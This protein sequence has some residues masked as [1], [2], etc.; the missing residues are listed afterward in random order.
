M[1]Q[2]LALTTAQTAEIEKRTTAWQAFGKQVAL[3]EIAIQHSVTKRLATIVMPTDVKLLSEYDTAKS[4]L[5]KLY[6]DTE[7][8]IKKD[9]KITDD[10]K[11]RR[12]LPL[13]DIEAFM[14][15]FDESLLRLK[16]ADAAV[17]QTEAAKAAEL[18]SFRTAKTLE[19]IEFKASCDK[20]VNDT[21]TNLYTRAINAPDVTNISD[22]IMLS[23]KARLA[24]FNF[25]LPIMLSIEVSPLPELLLE[26]VKDY[27]P[28]YYTRYYHMLL[29]Q[30]FATFTHD[31]QH[32]TESIVQAGYEAQEKAINIEETKSL[33]VLT[34][35]ISTAT[36]TPIIQDHKAL[37]QTYALDM[38]NTPTT[39]IAIDKAFIELN[40]YF[41]ITRIKDLYNL[42]Q[43]QKAAYI[44][45]EKSADP[46]LSITGITF[47][48]VDKL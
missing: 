38:P 3:N 35:T 14:A 34:A 18:G 31:K 40:G 13:A 41:N 2:E 12:R 5:S 16:Q 47:K 30:K 28:A 46:R 17:K 19:F 15:K 48:I 32:P 25:M 6:N 36:A 27:E 21:V 24:D 44:C 23:M 29:E 20:L 39:H 4:I 26:I 1:S 45:A 10:W 33:Q 37:K 9:T 43:E 7:E 8:A 42:K 11:K 22:G